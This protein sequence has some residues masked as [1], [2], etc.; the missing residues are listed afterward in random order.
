[1]S[2]AEAQRHL[3]EILVASSIIADRMR[4]L[5][6]ARVEDDAQLPELAS[7][8]EEAHHSAGHGCRQPDARGEHVSA[9]RRSIGDL[10]DDF[11]GRR[12]VDKEYVP[13]RNESVR[14]ALR[15][16]G[17]ALPLSRE[18]ATP[19]WRVR[20]LKHRRRIAKAH[21]SDCL[22]SLFTAVR[23]RSTGTREFSEHGQ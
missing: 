16:P 15:L 4:A 12:V 19:N 1:M 21:S 13:L 20:K 7:A 10:R 18:L 5:S 22:G 23:R 2:S 3:L 6:S 8:I 17:S 14:D 11:R 9:R